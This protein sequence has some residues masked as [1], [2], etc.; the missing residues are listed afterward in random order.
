METMTIKINTRSNK[1]KQL[2]NLITEMEKEG[3][4]KIEKSSL[5]KDVQQ[6]VRDMKAGRVK[7][8]SELFK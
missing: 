6:G 3:S 7:P 4:A 2:V 5:Y 1:G 8:I